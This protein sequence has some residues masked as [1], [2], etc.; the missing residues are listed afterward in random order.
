MLVSRELDFSG[1][2]YGNIILKY[3]KQDLIKRGAIFEDS[4]GDRFSNSSSSPQ[5]K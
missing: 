2:D 5:S 3:L 1:I 4:P